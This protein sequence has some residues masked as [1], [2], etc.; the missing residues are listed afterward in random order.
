LADRLVGHLKS[1]GKEN[2][3]IAGLLQQMQGHEAFP[4]MKPS[5]SYLQDPQTNMLKILQGHTH[6]VRAT[7]IFP[8]NKRVASASKDKTLKI[9][10]VET[11]EC[12]QTLQSH[13]D[14]VIAVVV[15]IN[16]VVS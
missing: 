1:Y 3:L 12:L 9:W 2:K 4:F 8:N 7:C 14:F 10:D 11:G 13:T 16:K 6:H 5:C 15:F